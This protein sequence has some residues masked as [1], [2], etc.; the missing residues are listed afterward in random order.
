MP[1][2]I[3][4]TG[5]QLPDEPNNPQRCGDCEQV[6]PE[7]KLIIV[8]PRNGKTTCLCF[9]CY[10][11]SRMRGDA[12]CSHHSFT[13]ARLEFMGTIALMHVG[14]HI[15]GL[16]TIVAWLFPSFARWTYGCLGNTHPKTTQS[17]F[18]EN[19]RFAYLSFALSISHLYVSDFTVRI[20]YRLIFADF[21]NSEPSTESERLTHSNDPHPPK[22]EKT[23]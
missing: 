5:K 1:D 23:H 9:D 2:S 6:F 11:L 21:D 4:N 8:A 7:H 10:Y 15:V 20:R 12:W 17:H 14:W 22:L 18:G 3:P 19:N 16:H 13:M